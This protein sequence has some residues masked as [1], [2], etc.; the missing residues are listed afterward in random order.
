MVLLLVWRVSWAD[1]RISI[2]PPSYG[3]ATASTILVSRCKNGQINVDRDIS[4]A[5]S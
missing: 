2:V 4:N 1:Y 5:K 3:Q